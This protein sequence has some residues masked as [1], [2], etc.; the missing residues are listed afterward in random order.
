MG[1]WG[2]QAPAQVHPPPGANRLGPSNTAL[3][4]P[5]VTRHRITAASWPGQH[6]PRPL[7]TRGAQMQQGL[8]TGGV[9]HLLLLPSGQTRG[10]HC[11]S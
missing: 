10:H 9:L 11:V 8:V 5:I 1:L 6:N 2:S 3:P 7:Q 4:S